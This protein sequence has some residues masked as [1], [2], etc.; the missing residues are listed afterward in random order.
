MART[1]AIYTRILGDMPQN[2]D[3]RTMVQVMKCKE[4]CRQNGYAVRD[5][6][7]F[8]ESRPSIG[9]DGNRPVFDSMMDL[10]RENPPPFNAIVVLEL[11]RFMKDRDRREMAIDRL[12][13]NGVRLLAIKDGV[14]VF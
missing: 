10:A 2:E 6:F 12:M 8:S 3:N 14:K 13:G 1:A 11:A 4:Y 7:V 9:H 5:D